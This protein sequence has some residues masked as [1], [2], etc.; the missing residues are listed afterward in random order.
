MELY[1]TVLSCSILPEGQASLGVYV[2]ALSCFIHT[3]T[4]AYMGNLCGCGSTQLFHS[5][6]Y[7]NLYDS[8]QLS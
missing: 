3:G 5:G 1:M 7:G 6:P 2:T 8:T 4:S